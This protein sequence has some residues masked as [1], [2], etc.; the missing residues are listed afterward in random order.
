LVIL[1]TISAYSLEVELKSCDSILLVMSFV[2]SLRL[3]TVFSLSMLMNY[4]A[5]SNDPKPT[6]QKPIL[7]MDKL[8]FVL[9]AL[10]RGK[11]IDVGSSMPLQRL[12]MSSWVVLLLKLAMYT[13]TSAILL[14]VFAGCS[15]YDSRTIP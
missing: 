15:L 6:V 5:F 8:P 1:G 13:L 10:L 11:S 4:L 3:C 7:R 2:F 14:P 9:P 12:I